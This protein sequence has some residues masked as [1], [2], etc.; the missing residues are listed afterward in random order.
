MNLFWSLYSCNQFV[1]FFKQMNYSNLKSKYLPLVLHS[2]FPSPSPSSFSLFLSLSLLFLPSM[3]I[4]LSFSSVLISLPTPFCPHASNISPLFS[5]PLFYPPLFTDFSLLFTLFSVL[6]HSPSLP[7]SPTPSLLATPTLHTWKDFG[8]V[9]EF[10][11]ISASIL[12]IIMWVR[13][14]GNTGR[15]HAYQ[16]ERYILK[17]ELSFRCIKV[18]NISTQSTRDKQTN[19][20]N[21]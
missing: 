15:E 20:Q 16:G 1:S 17:R 3:P 10:I 12:E 14:C 21:S 9:P 4:H 2:P 6:K 18:L 7:L 5:F 11:N 13:E 19:T 8:E